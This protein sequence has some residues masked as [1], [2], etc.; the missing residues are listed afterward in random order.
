M[1]NSESHHVLQ[2]NAKLG[3]YKQADPKEQ[4]IFR[5]WVVGVLKTD[6]V[7]LTFE[8]KDGTIREM[9][10]TLQETMLP[11]IEKKTDRVRK[12][13]VEVLSVFDTE[14]QE[15]RSCRFD[16]IRNVNFTIGK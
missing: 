5:D 12:E 8:K 1:M 7:D 3:W 2:T 11:V 4:Q 13:N 6:T 10:A 15:W 16:S 9:K 14:K